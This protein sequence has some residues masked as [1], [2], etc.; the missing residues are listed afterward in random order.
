[1]EIKLKIETFSPSLFYATNRI[2][3]F[4]L[5]NYSIYIIEN[6]AFAKLHTVIVLDLSYNELEALERDTFTDLKS[7]KILN[8]SFNKIKAIQKE[9]FQDLQLLMDL[10][11]RDN[12]IQD[13]EDTALVNLQSLK[14]INLVMNP[15]IHLFKNHTFTGLSSLKHMDLS[16]TVNFTLE[17]VQSIK[18][19]IKT[20]LVREVLYM[21]F[22]DSIE[23][24]FTPNYDERYM[25][26]VCYYITYL[27]RNQISLNLEDELLVGKFTTDCKDWSTYVYNQKKEQQVYYVFI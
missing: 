3:N 16:E 4:Y 23:I 7:I 10:D 11:L 24:T 1:M 25:P 2:F 13:I 17:S 5:K 22:Y 6:S 27:I 18:K 8:L 19:Q 15:I 26:N 14:I 9:L 21:K 12:E 20:R